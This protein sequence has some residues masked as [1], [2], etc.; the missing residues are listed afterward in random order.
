MLSNQPLMLFNAVQ[1][2]KGQQD[3]NGGHILLIFGIIAIV[4]ILADLQAAGTAEHDE[5]DANIADSHHDPLPAGNG[6]DTGDQHAGP[7]DH[8][9]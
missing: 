2:D 3:R 4:L 9:T 8:F 6:T 7:E 5:D 1:R